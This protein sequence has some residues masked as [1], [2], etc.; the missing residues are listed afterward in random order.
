MM[1]VVAV[2]MMMMMM[3]IMIKIMIMETVLYCILHHFTGNCF[4]THFLFLSTY[5]YFI[6]FRF[7]FLI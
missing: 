6:L 4:H 7:L 1:M 3:L 2:V 5:D